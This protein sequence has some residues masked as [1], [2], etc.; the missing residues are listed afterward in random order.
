MLDT[1]LAA[2][3]AKPFLGGDEPIAFALD[4]GVGHSF[5]VAQVL[6]RAFAAERLAQK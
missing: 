3:L 2:Y 5:V 6:T 1:T 4:S